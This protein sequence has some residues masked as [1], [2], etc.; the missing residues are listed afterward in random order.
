MLYFNYSQLYL[1]SIKASL[2][3]IGTAKTCSLNGRI[4]TPRVYRKYNPLLL[5]ELKIVLLGQV[6]GFV[7]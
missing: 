1:N 3:K 7:I 2:E 5:G 4:A 6:F